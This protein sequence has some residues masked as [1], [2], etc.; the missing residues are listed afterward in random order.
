MPGF[1]LPDDMTKELA[2]STK[3]TYASKLNHL[4][5]AGFK[6][7]DDLMKHPNEV[8]KEIYRLA[9]PKDKDGDI[10]RQIRRQYLCAVFWVINPLNPPESNPYRD[11]FKKSVQNYGK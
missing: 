7:R 11:A 2:P 9:D 5:K 8:V 4:A 10:Q 1:E 6:N 3:A